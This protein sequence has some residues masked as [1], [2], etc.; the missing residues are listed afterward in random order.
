MTKNQFLTDANQ[1]LSII[2]GNA[3]STSREKASKLRQYAGIMYSL[4]EQGRLS[5]LA[6]SKI[7]ADDLNE[8]VN[9]RRS[10]GI[11]ESTI[12]KDLSIIGGLL[13]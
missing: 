5:T 12:A 4:Y 10:Q 8:Y 3:E 7:T 2:V 1:Y 6:A 11:A 13:T 9:F